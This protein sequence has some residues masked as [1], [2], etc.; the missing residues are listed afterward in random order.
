MKS[1]AK[2]LG[3]RLLPVAALL[4]LI[5]VWRASSSVWADPDMPTQADV[6]LSLFGLACTGYLAWLY[7]RRS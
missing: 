1:V 5:A 7:L 6:I 4:F 3:A 2:Y